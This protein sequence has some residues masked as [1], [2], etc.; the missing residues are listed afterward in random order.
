MFVGMFNPPGV[1]TANL[2]LPAVNLGTGS[3]PGPVPLL[4]SGA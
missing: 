3:I 2:G 1:P 4:H